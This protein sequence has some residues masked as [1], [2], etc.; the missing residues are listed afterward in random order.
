MK[1]FLSVKTI[2][3]LTFLLAIVLHSSAQQDSTNSE[4]FYTEL[5]ELY[6]A[7]Q[8]PLIGKLN[9]HQLKSKTNHPYLNSNYQKGTITL[10]GITHDVDLLYDIYEQ[11]VVVLYLDP[12]NTK[13][14]IIPPVDFISAFNIGTM[15]FKQYCFNE[16]CNFYQVVFADTITCLYSWH[17]KRAESHEN[18][19]YV[20]YDYH[21][22][23]QR[24]YLLIDG[25]ITEYSGNGSFVKIFPKQYK[26]SITDYL[27]SND[28]DVRK[29]EPE[30]ISKLVAHCQ[31]YLQ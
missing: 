13:Y 11:Q 10:H 20:T 16:D 26:K 19:S 14:G 23:K 4:K 17:K 21:S 6:G 22:M 18:R 7:N 9:E 1:N 28:I 15:L 2:V 27:K 12:H 24:S 25:E 29:S 30:T 3:F 31:Q 5:T 8:I